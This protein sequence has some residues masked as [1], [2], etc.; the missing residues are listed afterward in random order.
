MP[1]VPCPQ[2]P[3]RRGRTSSPATTATTAADVAEAAR[4]Q[5]AG[6]W[7]AG[8]LVQLLTAALFVVVL[9]D[10]LGELLQRLVQGLAM[11]VVSQGGAASRLLIE[12]RCQCTWCSLPGLMAL[13]GFGSGRS[14]VKLMVE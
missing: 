9:F 7:L 8:G 13:F 11:A 12:A 5:A 1:S 14:S 10:A 2:A 3:T 6:G 4:V